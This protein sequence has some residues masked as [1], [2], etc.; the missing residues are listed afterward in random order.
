MDIKEL[1]H[2]YMTGSAT[3]AV[4]K[5]L[6]EH[7]SQQPDDHELLEMLEE[8]WE[9]IREPDAPFVQFDVDASWK[10]IVT[11][12]PQVKQKT[13]LIWWISTAAAAAC[14]ISVIVYVAWTPKH[15]LRYAN[16]RTST[17]IQP[18]KTGAILTLSDGSQLSLDSL[19]SGIV[20]RQGNVNAVWKNGALNY[21]S[22]N[23][24]TNQPSF[25][26][27]TTPRGRQFKVILPDQTQVWLNAGSS[28]RYPTT[29]TGSERNVEITG[30]VYFEVTQS[31]RQPFKVNVGGRATVEV[32]GTAFNINAY[33]DEPTV[34][35]SLVS[36]AVRVSNAGEA[37]VLQPG[38][39]AALAQQL[40]INK[41]ANI[42]KI[43]AWKNGV[44]SFEDADLREVLRQISRWYDVEIVYSTNQ[45]P[46][47][48]FYGTLSR[49]LNLNQLINILKDAD[50]HFRIED[51]KL[52]I[53]P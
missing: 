24:K 36:G 21:E 37:V 19:Q 38:Q 13:P 12:E 6:Q 22:I 45:M 35:T 9:S 10:N 25:N 32:L 46:S 44:F 50:V 34:K 8:E 14:L 40:T 47:F 43:L 53:L 39:Q 17:I 7:I 41:N 16:S 28:I 18:G 51:K 33:D 15:Q 29:F 4:I 27:V 42:E 11:R 5:E 31:A 2:Q 49:D 23:S 20:A 26:T 48:T 3:P 1:F 52:I 30:E